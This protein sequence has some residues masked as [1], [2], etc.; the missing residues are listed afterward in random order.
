MDVPVNKM[1]Y[2]AMLNERGGFESDLTIIRQQPNNMGERY[3]IVTGSAQTVRDMDWIGRH[4]QPHEHAV[5][6]DISPLYSVLSVMGPK[7]RELLARVS[8]DDLSPEA[9][10]FSWTRL[11]DLGHARVRAA[12][13][14]YVGGPGFELYVPV[15]MTRHVYLALQEAGKQID[16]VGSLVDAGYYALDALRIEM[17]RRA[18]GAEIGP[19]ETPFEAGMMF[20]VRLNKPTDFI[21]KA[22]LLA[23]QG[24]PLRK[25]LVTVVL[26]T[27]SAYAWGGESL[28][29]NGNTVGELSSVGWS[30]RAGACVA[31]GYV[32]GTA[33]NQ[34]HQGTPAEIDLWGDRVPVRLYDQWVG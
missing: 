11:I 21:G 20:T 1:V 28:I 23:A 34:P 17:G 15:E 31:L 5:L 30:P 25:K 16:E 2:T 33:A 8:P 3:L 27:G 18:W 24:K 22:A 7:A 13:M 29:L 12:R 6:T 4:I 10:K 9:L 19:D 14:S 32:R 26:K